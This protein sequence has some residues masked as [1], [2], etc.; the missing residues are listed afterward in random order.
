MRDNVDLHIHSS[1][2]DG[3]LSPQ[4]IITYFDRIGTNIIS[5]TDH[6]TIEAYAQELDCGN[7]MVISGVEVD[8]DHSL[9]LQF[10]CY[11]FD[12]RHE[13]FRRELQHVQSVRMR[14][15]VKL[16]RKLRKM[17][18]FSNL[19]IG[20]MC[21]LHDFRAIC[22]YL[23]E[24]SNG[25]SAEDIQQKYFWEGKMLY[26]Q[27][28]TMEIG[29][30]IALVHSAGG[31]VLLAHPGRVSSD[32]AV[33]EPLFDDLINR[34]IDGFECCHPDHDPQLEDWIKGYCAQRKCLYTGGSDMHGSETCYRVSSDSVVR[35]WEKGK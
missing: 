20:E 7:V 25:D 16:M 5:I 28:S 15:R 30:C 14:A 26:Q 35:F 24:H 21:R 13:E 32:I 11:G 1:Y 18:C 3:S 31:V 6:N 17:H 12:V 10:L 19:D 27:I 34:G 4:E 9:N 8:V 22:A 2:S 23:A 33:L 29:K